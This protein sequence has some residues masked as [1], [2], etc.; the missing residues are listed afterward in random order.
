MILFLLRIMNLYKI[1]DESLA[2]DKSAILICAIA[3]LH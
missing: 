1:I 3:L 2:M